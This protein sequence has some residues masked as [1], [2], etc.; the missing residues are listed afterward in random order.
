VPCLPGVLDSGKSS[1]AVATTYRKTHPCPVCHG[2]NGAYRKENRCK[3]FISEKGRVYCSRVESPVR[4]DGSVPLPLS[5][6]GGG[7]TVYGHDVEDLSPHDSDSLSSSSSPSPANASDLG[8]FRSSP[9][10]ATK[11]NEEYSKNIPSKEEVNT[12]LTFQGVEVREEEIPVPGRT[13]PWGWE[14]YTQKMFVVYRN[15]VQADGTV[16]PIEVARDK[17]LLR[18]RGWVLESEK[19]DH[20]NSRNES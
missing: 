5:L 8:S 12:D 9:N 15:G 14:P 2:Y 11:G 7:V 16:V 6:F 3:G 4:P 19:E 13:G 1:V 18:L 20:G 10:Q 17:S